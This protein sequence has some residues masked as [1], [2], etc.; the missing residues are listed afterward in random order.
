[1]FRT[2][3]P[4]FRWLVGGFAALA[5]CAFGIRFVTDSD[6]PSLVFAVIC[7]AIAGYWLIFDREPNVT[8]SES[9]SQTGSGTDE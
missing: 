6:R 9:G 5:A 2:Q 1:M 7:L 8:E 3:P 4:G